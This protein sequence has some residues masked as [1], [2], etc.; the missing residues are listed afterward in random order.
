[1]KSPL[2]FLLLVAVFLIGLVVYSI[3]LARIVAV[4]GQFQNITVYLLRSVDAD[5]RTIGHTL[6]L[7]TPG[8]KIILY[9]VGLAFLAFTLSFVVLVLEAS[10]SCDCV[11]ICMLSLCVYSMIERI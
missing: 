4:A 1:M 5:S 2:R 6:D 8:L 7:V 10:I 11:C 3:V 9:I